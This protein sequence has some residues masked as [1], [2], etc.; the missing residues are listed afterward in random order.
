MSFY[1]CPG[2][3]KITGQRITLMDRIRMRKARNKRR[4][5]WR[6]I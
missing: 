2:A 3:G 5:E 1:Y 4:R 6:P